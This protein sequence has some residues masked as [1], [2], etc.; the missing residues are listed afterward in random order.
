MI[1]INVTP[2]ND[3]PS[4]SSQ[5]YLT[6][7]NQDD[8]T[9]AGQTINSMFNAGF[10]DPDGTFTGVAVFANSAN[11]GTQGS[12]QYS[13]DG[14]TWYAIGTSVNTPGGALFLTKNTYVRFVP[15]AGYYGNPGGLIIRAIDQI[16]SNASGTF[17]SGATRLTQADAVSASK[18]LLFGP[19]PSF[20]LINIIMGK[21]PSG[22]P[23]A[24]DGGVSG[25]WTLATNWD[26]DAVPGTADQ[27]TINNAAVTLSSGPVNTGTLTLTGTSSLTLSTMLTMSGNVTVNGATVNVD[28]SGHLGTQGNF[29]TSGVINVDGG[30][31]TVDSGH[32]S[33]NTGTIN[34]SNGQVDFGLLLTNGSGSAASLLLKDTV[35]NS[36]AA[37]VSVY[38]SIT[39]ASLGVIEIDAGYDGITGTFQDPVANTGIFRLTS[40]S[41][42]K[43]VVFNY[44]AGGQ[45]QNN[46]GG[47]FTVLEG[48][49]GTRSLTFS[50]Q[51]ANAVGGLVN[52]GANTNFNG[53]IVSAGDLH[54]DSGKTL[55]LTN[56]NVQMYISS[57]AGTFT[58]TGTIFIDD[59]T[60]LVHFKTKNTFA[61]DAGQT[62]HLGNADGGNSAY[63]DGDTSAT[64]TYISG[65][66]QIESGQLNYFDTTILNGGAIHVQTNSTTNGARGQLYGSSGVATSLTIDVGGTFTVEANATTS[67]EFT[68]HKSITNN[69]SILLISAGGTVL[70][71]NSL[72]M[73]ERFTNN[74][75]IHVQS[76]GG[77]SSIT[78]AYFTNSAGANLDLDNNTT[79]R[80]EFTN[81]GTISLER[82]TTLTLDDNTDLINETTGAINITGSS[83]IATLHVRGGD[84]SASGAAASLSFDDDFT[85]G[86]NLRIILGD[87][88]DDNSG[89]TDHDA[90]LNDTSSMSDSKL[91]V[92][93]ELKLINGAANI[94]VDILSGGTVDSQTKSGGLA[95]DVDVQSGGIL[96]A[97][98]STLSIGSSSYDFTNH[99]GGQVYVENNTTNGQET[100]LAIYGGGE[101]EGTI[102]VANSNG[103]T[104]D[105]VLDIED[106][107]VNKAGA[108]V[109]VGDHGR[110]EMYTASSVFRNDAGGI[111]TLVAGGVIDMYEGTLDLNYTGGSPTFTLAAGTLFKLGVSFAGGPSYLTSTA[112]PG[113][114]STTVNVAGTMF[115][116][117][118]DIST[119]LHINSGGIVNVQDGTA[120]V[121]KDIT[122]DS[123]GHLDIT[124]VG[125]P[126]TALTTT[127]SISNSGTINFYG[128]SG[129]AQI[130]VSG[131]GKKLTNQTGSALYFNN[132]ASTVIGAIDNFA[133]IDMSNGASAHFSIGAA[134]FE[135]KASG[136]FYVGLG[137]ALSVTGTGHF[138][139]AGLLRVEDNGN[140]TTTIAVD[141]V[142]TGNI[143][144]YDHSDSGGSTGNSQ[145]N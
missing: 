67:G 69:G 80:G 111:F 63:W 4:M 24:W 102:T 85:I 55:H 25:S 3:R 30:N 2:V 103:S 106:E 137:G 5:Q 34:V 108:T 44:Q 123:G 120:D 31:V 98:N 105:A 131:S 23:V 51:L 59:A 125:G 133:I 91:T 95:R 87:G 60:N 101:N 75:L 53:T 112:N 47:T 88:S 104:D 144:V 36:T 18:P 115:V 8:F 48:L 38:G 27:V 35:S 46:S 39:N 124:I 65:T 121:H 42:A 64:R 58:G 26:T 16:Y 116:Q 100:R 61:L 140:L 10:S 50:G 37:T 57:N 29:T 49:G 118:G 99:S 68:I 11:P 145:L 40:S 86:A 56:G 20:V 19:A 92:Q 119:F 114:V 12:W 54:V 93:G 110:L 22:V 32:N 84:Q 134:D 70:L 43:N 142:N 74:N 109:S 138:N 73:G 127:E 117:K 14:S 6:A 62:I 66:V 79:I 129:A 13:T 15:V 130:D 107:F 126:T 141:V 89:F 113:A 122:I 71:D 28:S 135:N 41:A 97:L 7:I 136:Q 96:R 1:N 52:I 94:D 72:S 78:A 17:T 81:H 9:S 132:G 90:S 77:A 139:N 45:F 33:V 21:P 128:G 82:G 143:Q 83:S 76:T